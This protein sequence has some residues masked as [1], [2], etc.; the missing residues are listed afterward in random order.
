MVLAAVASV[1]VYAPGCGHDDDHP[2][3]S[4]GDAIFDGTNDEALATLDAAK[5]T[6]D[7][8]RAPALTSPAAS[9]RLPSATVPTFSWTPAGTAALGHRPARA[10]W[11][12]LPLGFERAADAH[13][14]A[15]SGRAY[16]LV[17]GVPGD[18]A[19]LRVFTTK[20]SFTPDTATWN[21]LRDA[22]APVTASVIGASFDNN[23]LAPGGGPFTGA[24]VSFTI[25]R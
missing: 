21:K 9:A 22:N 8:A 14:A 25:D 6:A 18:G 17:L 4:N 13:G 3:S 23:N 2:A 16:L 10:R 11:A 7:P 19:F 20:T 1:A 12:S 15:V 24:S 5:I